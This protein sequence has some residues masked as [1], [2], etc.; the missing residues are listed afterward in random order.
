[1]DVG[2]G[3]PNAVPGLE[4]PSLLEWARRAEHRG[5]STLGTIDRL[6]YPTYE[7]LVTL[8]AAAAVTDRIR[9]ATSIL[10]APVRTNTP[11]L[12][13][14]AASVDNISGGRLV[15]GLAVGP[16]EEDYRA[17]GIDF[18]ARGRLFDE[19]LGELKSIW[20]GEEVD[21]A[22]TVGPEPAR[23]GGPEL[24]IGGG[25]SAAFER[26]AR[27]GHGWIMGGGTPDQ[28]KEGREATE[29]AWE[30]QG[31]SGSPRVGALAYYALG[32]NAGDYADGYIHDYYGWL[33]DVADQIAASVATDE[34][35]VN[36]YVAA[37]EDAGCDE[38]ILFPCATDVE[39]VDLLA[40]ALG[41]RL[42]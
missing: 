23:E 34:D 20:A 28:F 39:Q 41:D 4:G 35:T 19:Q 33:G 38:L 18:G 32:P 17:S 11:L 5:F 37:F 1:M 15:L 25:V 30:E 14:Q 9:L 7:S 2:I 42:G 8:S 21:G 12:A 10:I 36:G 22:G 29:R 6:V 24:L 27:H 40:D 26:A 3:L 16:R 31:R 13:K